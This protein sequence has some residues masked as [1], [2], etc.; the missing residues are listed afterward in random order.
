MVGQRTISQRHGGGGKTLPGDGK[1]ISMWPKPEKAQV[2]DTKL[3]PHR[4][5]RELQ[6]SP[7]QEGV[8]L[9]PICVEIGC[10]RQPVS[11]LFK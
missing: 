3:R 9:V 2:S 10:L 1:K 4:T 8:P 7:E 5:F 6:K 11:L